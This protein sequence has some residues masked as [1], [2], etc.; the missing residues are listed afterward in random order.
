MY[1]GAEERCCLNGGGEIV[2]V[3]VV[4]QN[5]VVVEARVQGMQSVWW[6]W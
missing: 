3:D 4:E 6:G 2:S 5:E 1:S